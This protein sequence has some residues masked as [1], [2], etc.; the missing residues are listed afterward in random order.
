LS[1]P[2]AAVQEILERVMAQGQELLRDTDGVA[3]SGDY[4]SWVHATQRWHDYGREALHGAYASDKEGN[5]FH[6]AATSGIFR[7]LGQTEEEEF[8]YRCAA[9]GEGLNALKSLLERLELAEEP[10]GEENPPAPLIPSPTSGDDTEPALQGRGGLLISPSKDP[11]RVMVVFGRNTA[12][13]DAIFTFLRSVGLS[14]IEWETAVA[15]TGMGSPHNLDAVH[16]AMSAAQAVV[17]VL[18]AEDQAGLLPQLAAS[19]SPETLL[20]G[21]PRQNVMLEAGMAIGIDRARTILVEIGNLRRATDFEGLNAVRITNEPQKRADLRT[22]LQT[23]GCATSNSGSDWMAPATGGDFEACV[24]DW[25]PQ[26]PAHLMTPIAIPSNELQGGQRVHLRLRC[27]GLPTDDHILCTV[28]LPSG[29]VAQ[30]EPHGA[31]A[32]GD[33]TLYHLEYPKDFDSPSVIAGTHAVLWAGIA[34]NSN[35][36]RELAT[37]Q[38]CFP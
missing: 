25:E 4:T 18:T 33:A 17:V 8:E 31:P 34:P 35:A 6:D 11:R 14:P 3:P 36:S 21:Q 29:A 13:R 26:P 2:R 22:R 5:G 7:Q 16:A 10:P 28:T 1:K 30:A 38:F 15:E 12:A 27:Y 24:I 20:E 9:I 23:A 37:D 19:D 32:G